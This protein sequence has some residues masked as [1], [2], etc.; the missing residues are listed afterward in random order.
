MHF[1]FHRCFSYLWCYEQLVFADAKTH[2]TSNSYVVEAVIGYNL[3]SKRWLF[4]V[5]Y[6]VTD[7]MS[8]DRAKS[9]YYGRDK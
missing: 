2:L 5:V 9:Y 1:Y 3:C 8:R 4:I 6:R 7:N